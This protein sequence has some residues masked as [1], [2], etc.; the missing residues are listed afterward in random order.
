MFIRIVKEGNESLYEC[1]RIHLRQ[2]SDS[3]FLDIEGRNGNV[4]IE[5]DKSTEKVAIYA[6][7]S[8]DGRT[9]DT[10]FKNS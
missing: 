3:L 10:L 4:N 9:I 6:M 1:D 7:N 5:I 8:T 2:L